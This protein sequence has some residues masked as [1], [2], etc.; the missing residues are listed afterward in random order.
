[1]KKII[2]IDAETNGLRGKAFAIAGIA[3][4]NGKEVSRFIGRC[5]I[6]GKIN[7]W[8]KENVLHEMESIEITHRSYEELLRDFI[9]WHNSFSQWNSW[10]NKDGWR[11]LWHM[12][13]VVEAKLFD[14]AYRLGINGEFDSPYCPI[15]VSSMLD[16]NGY[17]PDSV[18]NYIKEKG[19]TVE[20]VEGGTHN[21]LYDSIVAAS[22]YFDLMEV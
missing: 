11:T 4:E 16:A 14:D 9:E 1:M 21:P 12:G 2:S 10:D 22:A 5:N 18:D 20:N 15:E 6:N 17:Q 13:H 8:V 19:L 3:Y 7:D